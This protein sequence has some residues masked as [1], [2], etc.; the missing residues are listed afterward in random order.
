MVGTPLAGV[1]GMGE[2]KINKKKMRIRQY[3]RKEGKG[4]I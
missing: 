3:N 2:G 1:L 4:G